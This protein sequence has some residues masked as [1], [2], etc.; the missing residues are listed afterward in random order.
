MSAE[1][2]VI[3]L[4]GLWA[5]SFFGPLAVATCCDLQERRIPNACVFVLAA[6]A[7]TNMLWT[8]IIGCT[9]FSWLPACG[10]RVCWAL[11][12]L[13][14][15]TVLERLWRRTHGGGHGFGFGD[16]KFVAAVALWLGPQTLFVAVLSCVLA[17]AIEIPLRHRSFAFGPYISAASAV[18]LAVCS[19]A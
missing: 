3:L 8:A 2:A 10:E 16:I 14:G 18:C 17:L 15:A 7:A 12:T 4:E 5:A 9:V 6:G 13:L 1:V 11:G 19:F